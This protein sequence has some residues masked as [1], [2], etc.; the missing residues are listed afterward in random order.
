[1][2]YIYIL[3]KEMILETVDVIE[4]VVLDNFNVK[5]ENEIGTNKYIYAK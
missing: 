3:K 1:M 2:I 5:R 4:N